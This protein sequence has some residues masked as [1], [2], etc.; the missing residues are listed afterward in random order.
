[1]NESATI[2]HRLDEAIAELRSAIHRMDRRIVEL[3]QRDSSPA[4][5]TREQLAA[6]VEAWDSYWTET[7]SE[8]RERMDNSVD[9]IREATK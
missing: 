3:E 9:A 4:A 1:M 6:I 2:G 8:F 5:V 7:Q